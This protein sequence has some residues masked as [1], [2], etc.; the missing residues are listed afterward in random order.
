MLAIGE[1]LLMSTYHIQAS[2]FVSFSLLKIMSSGDRQVS[3]L[4]LME[5][6]EADVASEVMGAHLPLHMG[7]ERYSKVQRHGRQP[8]NLWSGLADC[9]VH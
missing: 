8:W 4:T 1:S 7:A 6:I 9:G 3:R 2:T 5:V